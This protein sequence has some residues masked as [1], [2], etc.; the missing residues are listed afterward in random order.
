MLLPKKH[1]RFPCSQEM[2]PYKDLQY[3]NGTSILTYQRL[4]LY[5]IGTYSH[6]SLRY[7][8]HDYICLT[9]TFSTIYSYPFYCCSC[10]GRTQAPTW[11]GPTTSQAAPQN[12]TVADLSRF[13]NPHVIYV[14]TMF[15]M[16]FC[17]TEIRAKLFFLNRAIDIL[18]MLK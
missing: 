17:F 11:D 8:V 14:S 7:S 12:I 13:D 5:E 16:N 15:P 3:A 2:C 4:Q 9:S 10:I 6:R 1:I 18:S